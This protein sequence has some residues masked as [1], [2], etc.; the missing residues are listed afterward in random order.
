M[1]ADY[2]AVNIYTERSEIRFALTRDFGSDVHEHIYRPE[3]N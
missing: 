1:W 2:I 3:L